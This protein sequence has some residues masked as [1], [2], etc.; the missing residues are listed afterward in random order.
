MIIRFTTEVWCGGE[1]PHHYVYQYRGEIMGWGDEEDE[2]HDEPDLKFGEVVLYYV[3]RG[4]II[5]EGESLFAAM[6]DTSRD[7][8]ECY[9]AIF[10]DDSEELNEE[11]VAILSE[12]ALVRYNLLLINR[13]ELGES[14]RR[15]CVGA[16]VVQQVIKMFESSCGVIAC[17]S[18]PLQYSG[19]RSDENK[20]KLEPDYEKKRL[21]AF[22]KVAT[23]WEGLGFR[24]LPSS[25]F[26]V[27]APP[28]PHANET[29]LDRRFIQ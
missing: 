20:E 29:S 27:F 10:D 18:F 28:H 4:R 13:L 16:K 7:V 26:Y 1:E 2:D 17:K 22:H 12:D 21:I 5:D 19:Y 24:K 15:K 3:D 6:D 9:S 23:F 11:V 25:D 14:F 8:V